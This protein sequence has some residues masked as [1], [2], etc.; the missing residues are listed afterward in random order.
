MQPWHKMPLWK[1]DWFIDRFNE[2]KRKE[3]KA[4]EEA[5]KK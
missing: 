4:Y 2:E 1:R 3:N 5:S